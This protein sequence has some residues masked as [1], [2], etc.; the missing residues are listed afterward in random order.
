LEINGKKRESRPEREGGP[1]WSLGGG[2]GRANEGLTGR[3]D[4]LQGS[5]G[6]KGVHLLIK[7]SGS[8]R[9]VGVSSWSNRS[10][11]LYTCYDRDLRR[12]KGE[13]EG[14]AFR[15]SGATIHRPRELRVG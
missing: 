1:P 2:G 10:K 8:N 4:L 7:M 3:I 14:T 5:V 6:M 12:E 13:S 15:P 11:E 9:G